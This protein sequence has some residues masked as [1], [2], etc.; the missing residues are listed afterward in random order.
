MGVNPSAGLSDVLAG[1]AGVADVLQRAPQSPTLFVLAAGSPPPNPSEVLG[2]ARMKAL[3]SE[4]AGHAT[5][6]IDAPPLI[7]VT[8][9][10][11]LAHQAD[12]ALLVVSL[13]KTTYD[14]VEKALGIL[15]KA[16]GRALGIVLNKVPLKG[17][18]ASP[19][20]YDYQRQ[21][22]TRSDGTAPT[23]ASMPVRP[24]SD[25]DAR[26]TLEA[27]DFDTLSAPDPVASA[28]NGSTAK[29]R[30]SRARRG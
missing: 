22:E 21:Y 16:R 8:D 14:L 7:P 30:R 28:A 15:R 13:G 10:A 17:V 12:G 26:E 9:G 1:R 18:D 2:S 29:P 5:V 27:V 3:L 19:Y 23:V 24:A 20:S 11:V 25:A 4:L 6:I